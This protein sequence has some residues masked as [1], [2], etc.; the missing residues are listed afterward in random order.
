MGVMIMTGLTTLCY[1]EQDGKYLMLHR[2]K[3]EHDINK[4]KWIGVGGHFEQDESPDEC[5]RREVLEETGCT[6]D[7]T[8]L[9]G[10]VTFVSGDGVT[11][12][13]FLYTADGLNGD[14]IDCDEGEL[15]WIDKKDVYD[16]ELWEGDRIFLKLLEDRRDFFSLKLVYDGCGNLVTAILDSSRLPLLPAE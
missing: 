16:L 3:K 4:D 14:L 6:L 2:V 13:M 15:V 9:R 1:I 10:I 7:H 8:Y 11:E 12:Y 5:L